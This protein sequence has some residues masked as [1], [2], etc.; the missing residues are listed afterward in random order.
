MKKSRIF[1]G[2]MY[3]PPLGHLDYV[4]LAATVWSL[5]DYLICDIFADAHEQ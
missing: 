4:H 2:N 5:M 1:N 3:F